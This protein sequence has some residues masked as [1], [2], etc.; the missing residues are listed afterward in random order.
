MAYLG[1]LGF[2]ASYQEALWQLHQ[3]YPSWE[4]QPFATG[5]DWA[6]AVEAEHVLGRSLVPGDSPSSWKSVQDGAYNWTDSTWYVLDSGGWVA[7]SREIIAYYMDPRNFLD[8]SSVFQFLYQGFDGTTQTQEGLVSMVAGTFLADTSLDTDLDGSNG[9]TTYTAALYQAGSAY[10]VSP[11]VLASM[12]IQE[13]GS[14]GLRTVSPVPTAASPA[15]TM[16]LTWGR[17]RTGLHR[18]GAG[19]LVRLRRQRRFHLLRPGPGPACIRPLWGARSTIP[20]TLWPT[21]RTPST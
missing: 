16:R 7:A 18:R 19:T 10:G 11:Y 2:P 5:L 6:A 21:A 3:L 8:A 20:P 12:M 9:V 13:M 1:S 15:I 4:F 17:S 14:A